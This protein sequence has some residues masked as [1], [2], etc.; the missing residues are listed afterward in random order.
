MLPVLLQSRG[1]S[2]AELKRLGGFLRYYFLL[3]NVKNDDTKGACHMVG[4]ERTWA[5]KL[6]RPPLSYQRP[7]ATVIAPYCYRS[8]VPTPQHPNTPTSHHLKES[9]LP[10]EIAD[11]PR[12]PCA[13][14]HAF[15]PSLS[16]PTPFIET[17]R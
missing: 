9:I 13:D 1:Y 3:N 10:P 16:S 8:L 7:T 12:R 4:G 17:A 11:D 15:M 6:T 5:T 2:H 14:V